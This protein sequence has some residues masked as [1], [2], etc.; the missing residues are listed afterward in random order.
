[1]SNKNA[2]VQSPR[3]SRGLPTRAFDG[4]NKENFLDHDGLAQHRADG[5]RFGEIV[6]ATSGRKAVETSDSEF[7]QVKFGGDC[8]LLFHM[9][10]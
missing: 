10:E 3:Q 1:M 4:C 9:K 8:R 6:F 7:S 5:I 2:P